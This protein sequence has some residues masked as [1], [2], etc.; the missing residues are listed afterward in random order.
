MAHRRTFGL[1]TAFAG[2]TA[3]LL[4]LHQRTDGHSEPGLAKSEL[5]DRKG[6]RSR[7]ENYKSDVR[8]EDRAEVNRAKGSSGEN[9]SIAVAPDQIADVLQHQPKS[10]HQ[11]ER[12]QRGL[13]GHGYPP[14]QQPVNQHPPEKKHGE[15]EE[16]ADEGIK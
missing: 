15:S 3:R 2:D 12:G 16:D 11:Q 5:E 7:R 1:G 8:D 13:V 14:D 6:T 4:I 9:R 10:K